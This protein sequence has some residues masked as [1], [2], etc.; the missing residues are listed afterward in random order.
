M[1][2]EHQ[3]LLDLWKVLQQL[4]REFNET[5]NLAS[6]NLSAMSTEIHR[7]SK[8]SQSA[9]QKV[10]MWMNYASTGGQVKVKMG[11]NFVSH[12]L[13]DSE[14]TTDPPPNPIPSLSLLSTVLPSLAV[15]FF[16]IDSSFFR[17]L[18]EFYGFGPIEANLGNK[19][20]IFLFVRFH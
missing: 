12:S 14:S 10:A 15:Q 16:F 4:R 3:K 6:K 9:V 17:S 2:A 7:A 5:K 8:S 11:Q 20:S 13:R 19:R 1:N 18:S